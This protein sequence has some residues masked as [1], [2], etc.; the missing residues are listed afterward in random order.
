MN[1][2][3]RYYFVVMSV[4]LLVACSPKIMMTNTEKL[5]RKK[6]GELVSTLDSLFLRKPEFFY[7]KISTKFKDTNQSVS[8][9][10]SI[11]LVKDSAINATISYAAIPI[12]GAMLT[13][14][15]L[16]IVNKRSKCFTK[17][18]LATLKESLGYA[19]EFNNVEELLLGIP[20]GYDTNQ[21]YFQIY[22]PFN[23]I[24]SSHRKREIKRT[25][26]R[27]LD[28]RKEE[29]EEE[30]IIK[31]Y[32]TNDARGLKRMEIESPS[33]STKVQIDYLSREMVD[34]YDV[35]KEVYVQVFTAK[36]TIHVNLDYEKIEINQ[37][38]PLIM[39]IPESYGICE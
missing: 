7:S 3:I 14:D 8:F 29:D 24:I 4:L 12:F 38:Q 30:V 16:T 22:D 32:L 25:I 21:K 33:D 39:V 11:R 18:K 1:R 23:Y 28:K 31:Y 34:N 35:P 26:K 17:A 19:F 2:Y 10:T 6:T 13:T 9:K 27:K 36:N 5:E 37:R 20:L 15:S